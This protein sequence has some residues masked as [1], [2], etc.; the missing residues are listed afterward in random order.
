VVRLKI[1]WFILKT[2]FLPYGKGTSS[3]KVQSGIDV[4]YNITDEEG[5][6]SF[7]KFKEGN[8]HE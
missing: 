5:N 7:I 1:I 3:V 4:T 8:H 6:Y 2:Y